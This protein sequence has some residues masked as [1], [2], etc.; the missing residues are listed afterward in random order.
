MKKSP[1]SAKKKKFQLKS[2]LWVSFG[3]TTQPENFG[4]LCFSS[5][6]LLCRG[7]TP[8]LKKLNKN[9]KSVC[10]CVRAWVRGVRGVNYRKWERQVGEMTVVEI[11]DSSSALSAHQSAS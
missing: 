10:V 5:P 6:S 11:M 4:F 1:T 2:C 7:G 9:T 3:E 8:I